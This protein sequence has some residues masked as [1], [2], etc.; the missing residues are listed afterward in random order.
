MLFEILSSLKTIIRTEL[1]FNIIKSIML[2][3]NTSIFNIYMIEIK[4]Q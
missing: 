4:W 2:N 3:Q 1:F